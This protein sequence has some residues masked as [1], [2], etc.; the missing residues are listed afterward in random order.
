VTETALRTAKAVVVLWS[1][2]SVVSRWVR[3]EA[4]L[5]DRNKTLVPCTIEPCDRPIM[6]EL[7]QT[8]ELS[9]WQ[10][11]PADPAWQAFL[12]DVK[13]FV[14]KDV[15]AVLAA[16]PEA[17]PAQTTALQLSTTR[18][19]LAVLPFIN[20]SGLKEDDIFAFGMVEDI[21]D[22]LSLSRSIRVLSSGA[23][24]AYR[25][26]AVD[27]VEIA[28]QSNVRYLLEGNVRRVGE[29]LRVT[30]QLIDAND[31]GI[32]WTQKFD[33]P[34]NEL[35]ALQEDLVIEVAAHLGSQI[36][37]IELERALKKPGDLTAWE[38][39]VRCAAATGRGAWPL[40][41]AEG[42]KAVALAPD[43]ATAHAILAFAYSGMVGR[44][45]NEA[46]WR[47]LSRDHIARALEL[48]ASNSTVHLWVGWSYAW[49]YE[50]EEGLGYLE[51]AVRAR[52]TNAVAYHGLGSAYVML[53][54]NE[55]AL[56]AWET[57]ERLAPNSPSQFNLSAF[58]GC[59]LLKMGRL[60]AALERFD[61]SSR[62]QPPF[63]TPMA[64][65]AVM[66]DRMGKHEAALAE[67]RRARAL[68]PDDGE[69]TL[70]RST[71][72]GFRL[73]WHRSPDQPVLLATL[74]KLWDETKGNDGS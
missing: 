1:P 27:V 26:N 36:S 44:E 69:E 70:F 4:T 53:D 59:V 45:S 49:C 24:A 41:I 73:M 32:L 22:A 52:P 16:A 2:R 35:A 40:A 71:Q 13:Q 60:E 12:E 30:A 29:T 47:A 28:R 62:L 34:L 10:G 19:V 9:H 17:A 61:H 50:P 25:K 20:R 5:A 14:A 15:A 51:Q 46:H 67:L 7:T 54:R 33:R 65:R 48:D 72:G 31:G 64:V 58:M 63:Y 56:A 23:T 66:F 43:S 3:A 6:F 37:R 38:A 39:C 57:A 21:I 11:E 8:A 18:P 42:E 74:Q 55:E 68:N